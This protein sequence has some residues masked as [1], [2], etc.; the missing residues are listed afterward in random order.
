MTLIKGKQIASQSVTI[1]GSTGNVIISGNVDTNG[2]PVIVNS[3]PTAD[4]QLTNKAY[5]DAVAQG[6]S[7]HA[8]V[9]VIT[10]GQTTLS[11]TMTIDGVVLVEGDYV[12]VNG[13]TDQTKN[14]IYV[15]HSGATAWTR[16]ID[17]DG[18]PT[19]EVQLG[20]FVFVSNG[21]A[22]G[23]SGWVLGTTDATGTTI[24][25][26]VD[27]QLWYK[28]A[29]PGSYSADGDG[30][31]LAGNEF[32]LELDGVT[33][34]KSASGLKLSDTISTAI[35]TNIVNVTSLSTMLSSEISSTNS[36]VT[37][38]SSQI[39]SEISRS[40]SL[41]TALS[42]EISATNYDV[43]SLSTAIAT[44]ANPNYIEEYIIPANS[45]DTSAIV[46]DATTFQYGAAL[47]V[48]DE[49]SVTVF[50]NGVQYPFDYTQGAPNVF[51]TSGTPNGTTAITLYFDGTI[52]GFPIETND[53]IMM[54]YMVVS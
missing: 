13:Q 37:S 53:S 30:I 3:A 16:R 44:I 38:I 43:T 15:V 25:P 54:R 23:S 51:Y 6:V 5:V 9:D 26:G 47:G 40:T 17:A 46:V 10:T 50:L 8:P 24:T 41:T 7:P 39:S 2:Y 4:N 21:L 48:V 28:M 33:L 42:A 12:L 11:G 20:D 29:A 22:N 31:V 45:G 27:T 19:A 49:E 32:Q 35:S 36:D 1:S 52:A 18:N 14:G 34:S